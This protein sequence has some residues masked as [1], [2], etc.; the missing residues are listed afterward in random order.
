MKNA[1]AEEEGSEVMNGPLTSTNGDSEVELEGNECSH[2]KESPPDASQ[3]N[4]Q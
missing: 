3:H 1:R 4:C 2:V